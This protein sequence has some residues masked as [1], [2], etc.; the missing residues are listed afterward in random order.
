[1]AERNYKLRDVTTIDQHE[2]LRSYTS[3]AFGEYL[4]MN[5]PSRQYL[6]FRQICEVICRLFD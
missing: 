6:P 1:M 2:I 4:V 3:R 5:D